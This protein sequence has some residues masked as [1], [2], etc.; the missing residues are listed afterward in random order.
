MGK[1]YSREKKEEIIVNNN[2]AASASNFSGSIPDT[3]TILEI[4]LITLGVLILIKIAAHFIK[5]YFTSAV[6]KQIARSNV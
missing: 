4:A 5:K 6:N 1:S 2:N 3:Y